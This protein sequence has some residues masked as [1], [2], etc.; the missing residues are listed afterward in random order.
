MY[1]CVCVDVNNGKESDSIECIEKQ[2][3]P[4]MMYLERR[5][6]DVKTFRFYWT[7]FRT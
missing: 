2:A 4:K 3:D 5:E 1:I 7:F 6:V